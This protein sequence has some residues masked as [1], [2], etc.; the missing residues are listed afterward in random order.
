M[1]DVNE[2]FDP[3][4]L[5]LIR[6]Y[7][8]QGF[9]TTSVEFQKDSRVYNN[10]I[11]KGI[12]Y[13]EY[14]DKFNNRNYTLCQLSYAGCFLQ[15]LVVQKTQHY[16]ELEQYRRDIYDGAYEEGYNE[17]IEKMGIAMAEMIASHIGKPSCK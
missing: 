8:E 6:E 7:P 4:E 17:A 14:P 13:N 1:I 2:Q 3:Y 10:L 11:N 15:A 5:E 12:L 16:S 9:N